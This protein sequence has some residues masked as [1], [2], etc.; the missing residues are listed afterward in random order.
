M[1]PL[2]ED[3][4]KRMP[5]ADLHVHLDGSLRINTILDIAK[6]EKI[7]LPSMDSKVLSQ[8]IKPGM[9]CQSLNEYLKAFDITLKVLQTEESL[10]RASYEL[11]I[12]AASENCQY[13][14]VRYSPIL[15]QAKGLKLTTIVE[16][17]IAGLTRAEKEK[18][19]KTGVLICS[20]RNTNPE[21]SLKLAE[22]AIAY[23]NKGVVG[24]DLAGAEENY[25]PKKHREA[26]YLILDNNINTTV[27]AG[28]GYGPES[29]AQALHYCGAHRIGHGTR[30]KEDGDLLNYVNDHRIPLEICLSSNIQTK[31]APSFP[32]HPIKFYYDF[33]L[34]ITLNTDNRLITDT[35]LS[36]EIWLASQYYNLGFDD[37]RKILVSGF[38]SAFLSYQEKV[39]ILKDIQA[40]FDVLEREN[41]TE[42]EIRSKQLKWY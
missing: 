29:I 22:L 20:I 4:I 11:A 32:D 13:L 19:I 18:N 5:K 12:D 21:T 1:K 9:T 26:F 10:F 36:K 30:L 25:P 41:K 3:I 2:T 37:I 14:E 7:E 39:K 42:E 15:H 40:E 23:K 27:H 24:F 34:R 8:I 28:E 17:V 38:K 33:G 16:S 6:K 35:T 31:A